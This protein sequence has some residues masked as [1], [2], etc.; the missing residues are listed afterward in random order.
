MSQRR[1]GQALLPLSAVLLALPVDAAW[2]LNGSSTLRVDT[3]QVDGNERYSPYA[4]EGTFFSHELDLSVTGSSRPGEVWRFDFSGALTDSPY[5]S[6]FTGLVP[7]VLRMSYDNTTAALPFR[8]DI[9]DQNVHFSDLTLNR[10]LK[11]GRLTL[12]PN[13]GVAGRNYWVSAVVGS[14]GQEWRDL[15]FA[16]NLYRGFSLGMQDR[17]L[18]SYSFY[19][20]EH[21][22]K[23][24]GRQPRLD[25]WTASMTAQR[26]FDVAGQ[27]LNLRSELAYFHGESAATRHLP[28]DQRRRS[29]I[30]Y[31]TE[32]SGRSQTRPLDYRLRYERYGRDFRP[33]G[34]SA[35]ADSESMLAEGGVRV[36]QHVSLRGRLQRSRT[37]LSSHDPLTTDSA[38]LDLSA[39]LLPGDPQRLTGRLSLN[40]QQRESESGAVD[41]QARTVDG[42]IVFNH[43][44]S[45]QTRLSGSVAT[46]DDL[47]QSGL[48][49]RTR[50]F[51]AGHSARLKLGGLDLTLA[52]GV[53]LTEVDAG[54]D[55]FSAGPTLV[56]TATSA[57]ERLALELGQTELDAD[58][59]GQDV[60]TRL[61]ALSYEVRRGKH[62][63]GVDI[64]RSVRDPAIGEETEAWRVGMYWRYDLGKDL[65]STG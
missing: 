53:S 31:F 44:S 21:S 22:E 34:G 1:L 18:G 16:A 62:S 35:L 9:G 48:E 51:S 65:G 52:P 55:E 40:V 3:Y 11:A 25:Q 50:R 33:S 58:D 61:V 4:E 26:S 32:L 39:P 2:Q 13:S 10:T 12:R 29:G 8:V 7:E 17:T 42:S 43:N 49:R 63:F 47:N 57:N 41:Q 64:D 23:A 59:P 30:G 38:A 27:D 6:R 37:Q 36:K 46:V 14:N 5:R 20:V 54:E 56:V 60:E 24:E 19:L 28:A 45:H 15:D